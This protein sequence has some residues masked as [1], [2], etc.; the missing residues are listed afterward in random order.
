MKKYQRLCAEA[1]AVTA[2]CMLF[3]A[4]GKEQGGE[5]P[6][7]PP[8]DVTLAPE[9]PTP[10]PEL[11]NPTPEQKPEQ[12]GEPGATEPGEQ[13]DEERA[14]YAVIKD[15]QGSYLMYQGIYYEIIDGETVRIPDYYDIEMT[16]LV[17]PDTITYEGTDYRVTS[18]GEDAFSYFYGLTKVVLGNNVEVL[19]VNAFCGCSDLTEVV[20][21]TGLKEI[22]E[23]A[24]EACDILEEIHLP[25]GLETIGEEAFCSCASLREIT[26]PSTLSVLGDNMFFDCESLV[27]ISIPPSVEALPYGLFTNCEQLE[28]VELA[29]GLSVIEKEVFWAC[30]SLTSLVLPESL[31]FIGER[32]FYNS[33]LESITF[34]DKKVSLG[35]DIFDFCDN[36]TT[37]Y[38]SQAVQEYYMDAFDYVGVEFAVLQ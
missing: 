6:T 4:C 2:A 35:E 11:G 26:L 9:M 14:E 15:S 24:F 16:E 10:P 38:T 32:A 30:E 33:G 5:M 8:S 3:T 23:H 29:E 12:D 21:G 37:I 20:F 25:E 31:V 17:V 36:L 18:I 19:G 28:K 13:T 27:S 1:A 7:T 34:P 22:R